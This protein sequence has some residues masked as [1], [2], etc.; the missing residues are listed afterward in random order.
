M[1][2]RVVARG[3]ERLAVRGEVDL[4]VRVARDGVAGTMVVKIHVGVVGHPV[5][6]TQAE[7]A[8]ATADRQLDAEC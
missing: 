1:N 8:V 7:I 2:L 3:D 5:K 6:M 4:A